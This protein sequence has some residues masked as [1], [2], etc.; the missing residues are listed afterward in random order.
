MLNKTLYCKRSAKASNGCSIDL[1]RRLVLKHNEIS[2][3][4]QTDCGRSE[5]V[6][7]GVI[8]WDW[9]THQQ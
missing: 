2:N 7:D 4:M 3:M 1:T 8:K 6:E 5:C 9:K